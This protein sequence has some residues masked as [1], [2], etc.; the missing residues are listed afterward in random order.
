M[1][2][3]YLRKAVWV[4]QFKDS[5]ERWY[6]S[7]CYNL[8]KKIGRNEFEMRLKWILSDSFK[9]KNCNKLAY[10]YGELKSYIHSPIIE[11]EQKGRIRVTSV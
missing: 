11:P 5:K 3:W 6:V 2:Q 9:A 4:T 10:L 8:L 7:H 1:M